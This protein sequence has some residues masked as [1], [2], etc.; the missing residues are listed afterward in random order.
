MFLLSEF[1]AKSENPNG[2]DLT[3]AEMMVLI[4]MYFVSRCVTLALALNSS[5][6]ILKT[7]F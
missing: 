3:T 4:K 5:I 7:I 1:P 2:F 6:V